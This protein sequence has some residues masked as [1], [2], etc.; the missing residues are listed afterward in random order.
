MAKIKLYKMIKED[1]FLNVCF[2]SDDNGDKIYKFKKDEMYWVR[3]GEF[4]NGG[5]PQIYIPEYKDWYD[6][7]LVEDEYGTVLTNDYDDETYMVYIDQTD[8][9]ESQQ[10]EYKSFMQDDKVPK[11]DED[12]WSVCEEV[13]K[14]LRKYDVYVR[15]SE[16]AEQIA[17]WM[18]LG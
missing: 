4:S 1:M 11:T 15:P 2:G 16:L 5:W 10:N 12:Y 14:V 13:E 17:D 7:V 9:N 8:W 6:I 18:D 3:F